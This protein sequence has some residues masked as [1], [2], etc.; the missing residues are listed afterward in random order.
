MTQGRTSETRAIANTEHVG[1]DGEDGVDRD[2]AE[3][4]DDDRARGGTADIGRAATRA[5]ADVAADDSDQDAEADALYR[6]DGEMMPADC[7]AS[8]L[9]VRGC[10]DVEHAYGDCESAEYPERAGVHI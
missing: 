9:D 7:A 8:L 10:G 5:Q 1:A 2:D 4:A 6:A 3:D